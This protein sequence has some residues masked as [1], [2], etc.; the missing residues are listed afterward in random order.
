AARQDDELKRARAELAEAGKRVAQLEAQ[1]K[2]AREPRRL[3]ISENTPGRSAVG[4]LEKLGGKVGLDAQNANEEVVLEA[5]FGGTK[6]SNDDLAL[7]EGLSSLRVLSLA[8]TRLTDA[9]LAHLTGLAELR[10]LNLHNTQ[11]TDAGL[12]S[13]RGL[14]RLQTLCLS[15]TSVSDKGLAYLKGLVNLQA[16]SLTNTQTSND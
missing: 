1:S 11:T 2:E 13:L 6:V 8:S 10:K 7:L 3:P 15:T 5:D 4:A 14:T 16:L 12:A 9:G